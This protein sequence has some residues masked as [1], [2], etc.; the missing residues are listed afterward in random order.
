CDLGYLRVAHRGA[1][2]K[3]TYRCAAEPVDAYVAKGGKVEETVGRRCLCN[4]LTANI[5]QGQLRG[6]GVEPP[7]VTSGDD[8]ALLAPFFRGN[9][10]YTAAHVVAHLTGTA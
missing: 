2:A 3:V 7:L 4:G 6:E 10:G 8:L 5:G 1:D 9:P